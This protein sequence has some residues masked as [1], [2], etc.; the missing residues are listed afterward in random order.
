[1]TPAGCRDALPDARRHG[2]AQSLLQIKALFVWIPPLQSG[3]P[4]LPGSNP[5]VRPLRQRLLR[6][7]LPADRD[8]SARAGHPSLRS[9]LRAGRR[10]LVQKEWP[11]PAQVVEVKMTGEMRRVTRKVRQPHPQ[12]AGCRGEAR[13]WCLRESVQPMETKPCAAVHDTGR[14]RPREE[15]SR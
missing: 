6:S 14:A 8:G 5:G 10:A 4:V 11:S 13:P 15:R 7:A 9:S 1:M 3:W 12:A 2:Y